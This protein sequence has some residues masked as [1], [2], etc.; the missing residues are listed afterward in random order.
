MVFFIAEINATKTVLKIDTTY[1]KGRVKAF[2][3]ILRPHNSPAIVNSDT[4]VDV[5]GFVHIVAVKN[6][7]AINHI[8]RVSAVFIIRSGIG[9][10]IAIFVATGKIFV[11][12]INA[13][14]N[15]AS[16][17]RDFRDSEH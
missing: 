14:H 3:Y 9:Y 13:F 12:A 4:F 17:D 8:A 5:F 11:R 10:E 16:V 1:K 7:S 6:I 15:I 2:E